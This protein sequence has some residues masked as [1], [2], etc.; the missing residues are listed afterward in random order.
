MN[1]AII[2]P[3]LIALFGALSFMAF[4]HPK[5]FIPYVQGMLGVAVPAWAILFGA[6]VS[7]L[8]VKWRFSAEIYA[9][10]RKEISEWCSVMPTTL[11]WF[12]LIGLWMLKY[13]AEAIRESKEREL[14]RGQAGK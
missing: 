8:V 11:V 9:D 2:I 4:N 14:H 3:A 7:L 12:C 6:Q 5:T 13:F 10:M 1:Y